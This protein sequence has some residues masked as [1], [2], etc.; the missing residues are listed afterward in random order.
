MFVEYI[1]IYEQYNLETAYQNTLKL[2]H[3]ILIKKIKYLLKQNLQ[4]LIKKN[5]TEHRHSRDCRMQTCNRSFC[6]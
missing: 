1:Y 5:M 3:F 2:K 4:P 6:N